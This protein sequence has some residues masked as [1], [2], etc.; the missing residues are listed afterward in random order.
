MTTTTTGLTKIAN[1]MIPV[2]DQNAAI[3]HYTEVLG[4]ELRID[5]P[6][7]D[8]DRWIEVGAPGAESTIAL[9][10]EREGGW[11]VGRM[12]GITLATLDI[13][14]L[15]ARLTEA[16]VDADDIMR[17]GEPVPPMFFFRDLDGNTLLA[18]EVPAG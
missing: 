9:C 8:G 17:A 4:L 7:G 3:T 11:E 16:G 15:H 10:P 1:V 5:M 12:S 2:R 14:G 6:F 18:V 13:E